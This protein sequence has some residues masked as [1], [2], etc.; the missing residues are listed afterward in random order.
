VPSL[1]NQH[2]NFTNQKHYKKRL[3]KEGRRLR[4]NCQ[5]EEEEEAAAGGRGVGAKANKILK[6]TL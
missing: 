1:L 5:E 2:K 6:I 3:R 4:A